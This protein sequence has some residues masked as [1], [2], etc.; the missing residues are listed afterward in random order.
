MRGRT[1]KHN[2]TETLI[3]VS[4]LILIL[5]V[6]NA[7]GNESSISDPPA[8]DLEDAVSRGTVHEIRTFI[9]NG[10]DINATATSSGNPLISTA[11]S[12]HKPHWTGGV[13]HDLEAL[14]T[15]VDAGADVNIRDSRGNP[16]L[17]AAIGQHPD[18]VRILVAAGADV[19]ARDS[20]GDPIIKYA[21]WMGDEEIIEILV[22]AGAD[23][24]AVSIVS[25]LSPHARPPPT[26]TTISETVSGVI[27][28]AA[29]EEQAQIG[30]RTPE[31]PATQTPLPMVTTEPTITPIPTLQPIQSPS[32]TPTQSLSPEPTQTPETPSTPP[33]DFIS[34]D[35]GNYDT[36]GLTTD[37]TI[38]CWGDRFTG[39]YAPPTGA[40]VAVSVG[41][42]EACALTTDGSLFCL[43]DDQFRLS[44]GEQFSSIS[45]GKD[46]TCGVSV[47]GRVSCWGD[48]DYG[49]A[50]APN[51]KF[52]SVSVGD[53]H[54]CGLTVEGGIICWGR[55]DDGQTTS[56]NGEYTFVSSGERDTCAISVDGSI[57]CW[58]R[59][60]RFSSDDYT[61]PG[62]RYV[63]VS[64]SSRHGCAIAVDG[65]MVCWGRN[66]DG[67][68]TPPHRTFV[69]VSVGYD[70]S[71][72]VTDDGAALC[73]GDNF[74]GQSATETICIAIANGDGDAVRQQ[75]GGA[76]ADC[77]G[78]SL[79]YTAIT[80]RQAEVVGILLEAG[81]DPNEKYGNGNPVLR[82]AVSWELVEIVRLLVNAGADVNIVDTWGD[83]LLYTA[84]DD[85]EEDPE[86]V[87]ILLNAGADPNAKNGDGV[88]AIKLAYDES[89]SEILG[90]LKDAGA[91][92]DF[93]PRTPAIKVVDR[94]D[95]SLTLEVSTSG[96]ESHY[97]A[98]RRDV[99]RSGSWTSFNIHETDGDFQD[100]GLS[101][102]SIYEYALRACSPGGCSGPSSRVSGLTEKSG[103]VD[104]PATP[105][106]Q[107]TRLDERRATLRWNPM[108]GA[109]YYEVYQD[110]ELEQ[111]V[112]APASS[113]IDF[114]NR[115]YHVFSFITVSTDYTMKACNKAG[116][117]PF[118]NRI[119]L[120]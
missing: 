109:T 15:L 66:D 14:R 112:S 49:Q 118:S 87:R 6:I 57:V 85:E 114:L 91:L 54:T 27:T 21:T 62:G 19:N 120:P 26:S 25:P 34:I 56:P 30:Q 72:G 13:V 116:C 76:M 65:R 70:H 69:S 48:N 78:D 33:S 63:A 79:L 60:V 107:G 81:E 115:S 41:V 42:F 51:G 117:S 3:S 73:W 77:G 28:P 2:A 1:T 71:C 75:L 102:N 4:V 8:R 105:T 92:V 12:R 18:A 94:S 111:V 32:P 36:C 20:D 38:K 24:N 17:R 98:E 119:T 89:Y 83:A 104:V 86:I 58:G 88:S 5:F 55:N 108:D 82:I 35:A 10:A 97:A 103:P 7:C 16:V 52:T 90:M 93:P 43:N 46:H 113:V 99:T 80:N 39:E 100:R 68:G 50:T 96:V 9:A 59:Q 101:P 84:V 61:P 95:D 64:I 29:S 67:K 11:I 23:V 31:P 47:E 45:V 53:E 106:L 74:W 44:H 37:G 22:Q 110:Q 40:F